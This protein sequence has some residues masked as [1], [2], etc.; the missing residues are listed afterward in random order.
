MIKNEKEIKKF[1]FGLKGSIIKKM[2]PYL[3]FKILSS[4]IYFKILVFDFMHYAWTFVQFQ[5]T[6]PPRPWS[7]ILKEGFIFHQ[8]I[9]KTINNIK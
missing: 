3:F 1:C 9:T 5:S 7:V 8:A 2:T 4:E 6:L